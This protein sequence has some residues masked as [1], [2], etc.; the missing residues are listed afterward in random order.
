MIALTIVSL[1]IA[2][3]GIVLMSRGGVPESVSGL[4]YNLSER[5]RWAWSGWLVAVA[6]TLMVP[7]MSALGDV[8]WLGWLTVVCLLGAAVT[9]VIN[10]DT[11][12]MH[13]ICGVA[14]GLL[15][16][17]CVAC[18]CPWWLACWMVFIPLVAGSMGAYNDSED[19]PPAVCDGKGVLVAECICAISLYGAMV[20]S[21]GQTA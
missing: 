20:C 8:A 4:V 6:M 16:Q 9:P 18:L 1:C 13:N 2:V 7:L 5:M 3:G 17:V 12:T 11:R 14:A 21:C 10:R 19:V 15:S